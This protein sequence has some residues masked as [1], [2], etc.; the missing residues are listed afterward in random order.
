M[1]IT[2]IL[3]KLE[4]LPQELRLLAKR[5]DFLSNLREQLLKK[6]HILEK[7]RYSNEAGLEALLKQI[8]VFN[9]ELKQIAYKEEFFK[10]E[11][12][13]YQKQKLKIE[14]FLEGND[15]EKEIYREKYLNKYSIT[16]ISIRHNNIQKT[17]IHNIIKKVEK[18]VEELLNEYLFQEWLGNLKN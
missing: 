11:H 3:S 15:Y 7:Y 10:Q 16:K 2:I 14:S 6:A 9:Q 18:D 1:N 13:F 5:K 17:T 12:K 4:E 8:E